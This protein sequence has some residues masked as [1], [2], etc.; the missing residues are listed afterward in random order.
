MDTAHLFQQLQVA[1]EAYHAGEPSMTDDEFDALVA[2]WEAKSGRTWAE[3]VGVG[4]GTGMAASASSATA[5]PLPMW[6][7][8]MNKVKEA[9][10]IRKW[11]SKWNPKRVVISDKLDGISCLFHWVPS[12]QTYAVYTRGNGREGT[13]ITYLTDFVPALVELKQHA[14]SPNEGPKWFHDADL[15]YYVRGELIISRDCWTTEQETTWSQY[16]NPR[17]T[18][19][20]LVGRPPGTLAHTKVD[21]VP[22]TIDM[23]SLSTNQWKSIQK[24]AMFRYLKLLCRS[25]Q[26]PCMFYQEMPA[27]DALKKERLSELLQTR[28]KHSPYEID[29]IIVWDDTD[30]Y[31]PNSSGN[32]EYAFA[33]KMLMTEQTAETL[34]VDVEWNVSRT[35][36]WKPTVL[37]EP[38]EIGGTTIGRATGHN[39][40]WLIE[41]K[42]GVGARVLVV[43][44]GDVIPKLEAILS[45][46]SSTPMPPEGTWKWDA[47]HTDIVATKGHAVDVAV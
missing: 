17:N 45:P 8:S 23:R 7:G 24:S 12:Q 6:M 39:A 36:A 19:A 33:F 34:V 40:A 3:E 2:Q 37:F 31:E 4:V 28:R 18:V 15:E 13:D 10:D 9:A 1:N 22:F 44:S 21:F 26:I 16:K 5:R 30:A 25:D 11:V 42:I 32:P 41:R 20:G 27:E 38:V 43:R 14:K 29:G 35:G 46:A 47:K